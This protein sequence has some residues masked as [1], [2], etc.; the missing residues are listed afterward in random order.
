MIK[1]TLKNI[2]DDEA[3]IEISSGEQMSISTSILPKNLSVGENLVIE[4][5]T[6]AE[7][8]NKLDQVAKNALNEMLKP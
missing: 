4:I 2:K 6:N 5:F 3:L 7:Y 8:Q 1:A